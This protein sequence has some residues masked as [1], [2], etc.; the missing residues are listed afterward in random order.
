MAAR[1]YAFPSLRNGVG[2]RRLARIEIGGTPATDPAAYA[3]RSP[4]S[5]AHQLAFGGVP[6]DIW[7]SRRD[8]IVVDQY[9]E[10]AASTA[11]SGA[12]T[13]RRRSS[14]S[15]APGPTAPR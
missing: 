2:L 9:M 7:W 14:S 10:S 11:R 13:P 8:K 15:S 1:Y 3:A 4:M 12:Q 6:I 5:Y